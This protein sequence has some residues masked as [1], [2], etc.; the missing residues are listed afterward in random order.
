[1]PPRPTPVARHPCSSP[2]LPRSSRCRPA[3]A[4]ATSRALATALDACPT[5]SRYPVHRRL[6]L[7]PY[8]P[9]STAD[10]ARPTPSRRIK[11]LCAAPQLPRAPLLRPARCRCGPACHILPPHTFLWS[12]VAASCLL[13]PYV[14]PARRCSP[15]LIFSW[16]R[17]AASHLPAP[18]PAPAC[19]MWRPCPQYL[20]PARRRSPPRRCIAPARRMPPPLTISSQPAPSCPPRLLY[21]TPVHRM[22]PPLALSHPPAASRA[23]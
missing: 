14:T 12:R 6:T 18:Y 5:L 22:T 11:R 23:P 10:D 4:V 3:R 7:H 17:V 20:A 13:S 21:V 19:P 1:M 2:R 9:P 8:A 15:P 16:P